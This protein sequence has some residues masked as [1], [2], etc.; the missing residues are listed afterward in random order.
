MRSS[1]LARPRLAGGID[2][3][4]DHRVGFEKF[5]A[6]GGVEPRL[7]LPDRIGVEFSAMEAALGVVLAESGEF[8]GCER[9][10]GSKTR[11][12]PGFREK[13]MRTRGAEC[14]NRAMLRLTTLLALLAFTAFTRGAEPIPDKLVVLTFD[15]AAASHATFVA[16]LLKQFG[17]G[18]TF[19]VC[20]FPPDFD[21]KTKYM[22]WEQ[23]AALAADGFEVASH[24][25]THTHVDKLKPAQFV[26]ELET[27]EQ[28]CAAH[29][30]ARP[31]TFAYPAYV[32]TPAAMQTLAER[33][34]R[35]A[36]G[37]GG[38]AFDPRTDDP[39]LI[40]SFSTTGTNAERVLDALRLARDGKIVVLT[41]HGVPDT[42]H[43][44]VTTPPE[45]FERYLRFLRDEHYIVLALRDLAKY[46]DPR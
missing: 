30:I 41:I 22:S 21:D 36:R 15:D 2:G 16:P 18:A 24:T 17:F 14:C 40:P 38:R 3:G 12:A 25:H 33:G 31:T 8:G 45:L 23:I 4:E 28:R 42:A 10:G 35:F 43:P 13:S 26:A 20:E 44:Q 1:D 46:L 9:H 37:G 5:V 6:D 7:E 32:S 11:C 27:I 34:Y 19:F 29:G 39:R